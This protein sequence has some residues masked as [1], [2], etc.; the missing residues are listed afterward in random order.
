MLL[1]SKAEVIEA[2]TRHNAP[3]E[4]IFGCLY[5]YLHEQFQEFASRLRRFHITIHLSD[6]LIPDVPGK[7]RSGGFA[8]IGIPKEI[9]FDRINVFELCDP[10]MIT[11]PPIL[12]AWG[13]L[14]NKGNPHATLLGVLTNWSL[15]ER[16]SSSTREGDGIFEQAFALSDKLLEYSNKGWVRTYG[17]IPALQ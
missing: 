5:F 10:S 17:Q 12:S 15:L 14:L 1:C 7:I 9:V 13:P 11:I 3:R 8:P 16:G 6:T 4:D 2:G